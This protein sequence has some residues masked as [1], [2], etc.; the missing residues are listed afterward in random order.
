ME[1]A[2][3]TKAICSELETNDETFSNNF[4]LLLLNKISTMLL[5]FRLIINFLLYNI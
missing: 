4:Q 3:T 5:Y 2:N 1:I